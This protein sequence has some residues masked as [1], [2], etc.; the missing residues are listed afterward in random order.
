MKHISHDHEPDQQYAARFSQKSEVVRFLTADVTHV[1][2]H[3]KELTIKM[4][5]GA[6]R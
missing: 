1:A 5:K 3:H 4:Y 2:S 6:E